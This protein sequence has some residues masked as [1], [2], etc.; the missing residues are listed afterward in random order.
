MADDDA[1]KINSARL[2]VEGIPDNLDLIE[3]GDPRLVPDA[4][5][6]LRGILDDLSHI[7]IATLH[8]LSSEELALIE[9]ARAVCASVSKNV[10]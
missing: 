1:L 9:R 8:G 4:L 5:D 7:N 2:F 10:N 6:A 3:T